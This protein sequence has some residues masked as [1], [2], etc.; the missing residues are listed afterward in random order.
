MDVRSYFRSLGEEVGSL[1]QRV[2]YLRADPTGR[3]TGSGKRVCFGRFS[4]DIFQRQ[5]SS[6]G[7][8]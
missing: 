2:R 1:K 7:V 5:P 6:L 8:L 3:R 4:A